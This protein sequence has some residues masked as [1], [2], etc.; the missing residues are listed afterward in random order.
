MVLTQTEKQH[1]ITEYQ[2]HET[3]T[4]SAYIQVAILTTRINQLTEHLKNNDNDHS[5]RLGLLKIIGRRKG[6]LRYIHKHDPEGYQSL[7]KKLS[8]RG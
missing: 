8:I 3:D 5:S 2:V 1:L 7:I 4:G 6:L